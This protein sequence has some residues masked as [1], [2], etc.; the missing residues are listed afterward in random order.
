MVALNLMLLLALFAPLAA[1]WPGS[2]PGAPV[3]SGCCRV[4]S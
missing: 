2:L 1:A 3:G 4:M